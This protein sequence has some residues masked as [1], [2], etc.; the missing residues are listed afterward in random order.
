MNYKILES[1]SV[2]IENIDG[3]A[4]NNFCANGESG[5]VAGVLDECQVVSTGNV[6]TVGAGLLLIKGI[7]VKL[8]SSTDFSVSG[9]PASDTSYKVVAKVVLSTDKSVSFNLYLSTASSLTQEDLYKNNSGTYEIEIASFVHSSTGAI[10]KLRKTAMLAFS[11]N[12]ISIVQTTGTA[13]DKVMSQNAVTE[14]ITQTE[15]RLDTKIQELENIKPQVAKNTNKITALE[16]LI[17]VGEIVK[18]KGTMTAL[19]QKTGGADLDGFNI[20][21]GSF[22][23][24]DKILGKTEFAYNNLAD[25]GGYTLTIPV[26]EKITFT[27]FGSTS[28]D[29]LKPNKSY[30]VQWDS[31][32]DGSYNQANMDI[33][34]SNGQ[35]IPIGIF[36]GSTVNYVGVTEET[37]ITKIEVYGAD[38]TSP[39]TIKGLMLV[40]QKDYGKPWQPY[41]EGAKN[42]KISGIKSI[43]RNLLNSNNC[44]NELHKDKIEEDRRNGLGITGG[45]IKFHDYKV[46]Y[47]PVV[48]NTDYT[49]KNHSTGEAYWNFSE[50]IEIGSKTNGALNGA[51]DGGYSTANSGN[52]KYLLI[53]VNKGDISTITVN[54]GT[55]PIEYEPYSEH[56][57]EL[58][59]TVEL[60]EFD[61]IQ[62]WRITKHT[63][64][65]YYFDGSEDWVYILSS[66]EYAFN[67]Y[68]KYGFKILNADS[69]KSNST[70]TFS[71]MGGSNTAGRSS[72][73]LIGRRLPYTPQSTDEEGR[74]AEWKAY[75]SQHPFFVVFKK[76][77]ATTEPITFDNQYVVDSLGEEEVITPKDEKG[78]TCFDYGAN[79]TE[80]IV[81]F[82]ILGGN[83]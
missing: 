53:Q 21:D 20:A 19:R 72:L 28:L 56:L 63:S 73:Q 79:T 48:P 25:F 7:R 36:E 3:G 70:L 50:G 17:G 34:L 11:K 64:D 46:Y 18:R 32:S 45:T 57:I 29:A 55:T 35:F 33:H 41:F 82:A 13:T 49:V 71:A 60:G 62:D 12:H 4:F 10:T 40:E 6:L 47:V 61:Y 16:G 77:G 31:V 27:E 2:E 22:A 80:D 39:C 65:L 81:Y 51:R 74:L 5:I 58:P 24:V 37:L 83:E 75:L 14:A 44:L 54:F 67:L 15:Q 30:F 69:I 59:Q 66:D 38:G 1:N 23:T 42:A 8:L 68:G 52:Y 76:F 78:L 26:G 9:T 43:G